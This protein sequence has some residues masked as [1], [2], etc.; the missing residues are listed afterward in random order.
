MNLSDTL[1]IGQYVLTALSSGF[2]FLYF[3]GYRSAKK[4]RRVGATVLALVSLALF[5]ESLYFSLFAFF[6]GREWPISF[7]LEPQTWLALR[8]LFPLSSLFISVLILRKLA[9]RGRPK[10]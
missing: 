10:P 4:T 2:N 3:L 8:L 1:V 7:F 6:Q 5:G 9:M